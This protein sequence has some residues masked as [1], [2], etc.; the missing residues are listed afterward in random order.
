MN[1]FSLFTIFYTILIIIGTCLLLND[2]YTVYHHGKFIIK[3]KEKRG[4][5]ILYMVLLIIWCMILWFNIRHYTHYDKDSAINNISGN[6][7]WIE[8]S[9][10]NII[11]SLRSSEIREN[12]IYKSGDFYKWSKIKSYSWVLPNTL[13]FK[14]NT[15]LKTNKNFELTIDEEF[16]LKVDEVMQRNLAL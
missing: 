14:V 15:L 10:T 3:V 6:I 13:Q 1:Q 2:L 16:K 5:T 8:F 11:R 12:G 7:F 4:L 9:I